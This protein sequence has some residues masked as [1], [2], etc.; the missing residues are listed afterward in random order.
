M[1]VVGLNL[2]NGFTGMLSIGP[3]TMSVGAYIAAFMTRFYG[4][5]FHLRF[6]GRRAG[7]LS[8]RGCRWF[9][10]ITFAGRLFGDRDLGVW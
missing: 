1:M 6:I 5:N 8:G 3:P 9:A 4:L 10:H 7:C 2:I